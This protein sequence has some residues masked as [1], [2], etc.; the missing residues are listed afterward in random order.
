MGFGVLDDNT[1]KGLTRVLSVEQVLSER[2][3]YPWVI[4]SCLGE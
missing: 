1:I 3:M 2:E 4:S